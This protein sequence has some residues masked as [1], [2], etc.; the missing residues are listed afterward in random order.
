MSDGYDWLSDE[1]FTA[2]RL[3]WSTYAIE[4]ATGVVLVWTFAVD[5]DA[6]PALYLHL[7]P[8]ETST[9]LD[10][11]PMSGVIEPVRRTLVNPNALIVLGKRHRR[12]T[13]PRVGSEQEFIDALFAELEK[14][15][16]GAPE[17]PLPPDL[18]EMADRL[19]LVSS[20]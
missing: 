11:P 2:H 10:S 15:E 16:A 3:S 1:P 4:T 13:I 14:L 9:L 19:L 8:D 18:S 20:S 7:T 6:D 17:T 12:F 5:A